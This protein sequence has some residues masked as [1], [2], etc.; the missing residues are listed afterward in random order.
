MGHQVNLKLRSRDVNNNND[1]SDQVVVNLFFCCYVR[2]K[3]T[4]LPPRSRIEVYV[5]RQ[6]PS[7]GFQYQ[8]YK[9]YGGISTRATPKPQRV[10]F[11]ISVTPAPAQV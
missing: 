6:D 5:M 7:L 8:V 11:L 10:R 9:G 1:D 4:K 3:S 2:R